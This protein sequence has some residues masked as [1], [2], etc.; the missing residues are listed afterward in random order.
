[1]DGY[2]YRKVRGNYLHRE[3]LVGISR[4]ISLPYQFPIKLRRQRI[5]HK[6]AELSPLD[7]DLLDRFHAYEKTASRPRM[8][9]DAFGGAAPIDCASIAEKLMQKDRDLEIAAK[10]GQS[11]LEQNKDLQQRT[12]FLEESLAKSSEEM[13]QMKHELDRKAELLRVYCHYDDDGFTRET[14]DDS[15]KKRLEK[16]RLENLQLKRDVFSMKKEM[17]AQIERDRKRYEE[18]SRQFEQAQQ[19]IA[20]LHAQVIE[21]GE[22]YAAQSLVVEKLLR[23]ISLKCCRERELTAE[24]ADLT[25]QVDEAL[26]RQAELGMQMKELQ[27]RYAELRSMFCDAEEELS[28]FRSA[29]PLRAGSVDS[30]YDSLASELENSDSGFSSTPAA[31]ARAGDALNL[32]LELQRATETSIKHAS[33]KEEFDVPSS[34]LAEVVRKKIAIEPVAPPQTPQSE[35]AVTPTTETTPTSKKAELVRTLTCDA[36]TSCTELAG[37]SLSPVAT[38]TP[39]RLR[40]TEGLLQLSEPRSASSTPNTPP[41]RSSFLPHFRGSLRLP[42]RPQTTM[43]MTSKCSSDDSLEDYVAPKMG[44]PGVPGTRD[45]NFSLRMLKARRKVEQDYAKFLHRKGLPPSSFFSQQSPTKTPKAKE[46][47]WTDYSIVLGQDHQ[48][49]IRSYRGAVTIGLGALKGSEQSGVLS[50]AEINTPTSSPQRIS[51]NLLSGG[52]RSLAPTL[53]GSIGDAFSGKGI[54]LRRF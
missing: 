41:P 18:V 37:P 38:S 39:K 34:V 11:L 21:R 13:V 26:Q 9:S 42:L 28:R 50:R 40:D 16:T 15:L 43:T 25:R 22:D 19:Q 10:I 53:S 33:S 51:D 46:E 27:E 23:E 49:T 45:L 1:M 7:A 29:P 5:L 8:S 30:L 2:V 20:S 17:E 47:P 4:I 32:R 31:S 14:I 52:L 24:N 54:I 44:E 36:S 48:R 6:L 35:V 3:E 12:E